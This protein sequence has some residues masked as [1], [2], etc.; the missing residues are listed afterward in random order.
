MV[1]LRQLDL[2][3]VAVGL[4]VFLLADLPLAGWGAAGGAWLAQKGLQVYLTRRARSSRDPRTVVGLLA[5]S[6]IARGWLVAIV[7]LLVG[8]SNSHAGLAAAVMLVILFTV[9]FTIGM[10]VRPF[11][12][13]PAAS[14]ASAA[15]R[16]TAPRPSA[17]QPRGGAW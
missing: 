13:T 6:M 5:G 16:A 1:F 7:I 8:L 3:L 10:I 4:P 11:E 9:Y 2:V 17:S 14:A 12:I 15:S